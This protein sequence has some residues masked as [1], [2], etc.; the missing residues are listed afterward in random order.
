MKVLQSDRDYSACSLNPNPTVSFA[1]GGSATSFPGYFY[2]PS[3]VPNPAQ[4][5]A[6]PNDDF[7]KKFTIDSAAGNTFRPFNEDTDLYNFGP[8]N[9][10]Q[11]PDT[12]YT[13]GAMGHYELAEAADV[14]AQLMFSD[15]ES[16]AQIAPGGNFFDTNTINCDNPLLSAQQLGTI[17]C[18]AAAIANGDSVTMYLARRNTEGGGRQQRFENASFRAVIG[19]RGAISENWD[20][21]TS[22]QYSAGIADQSANNYFHKTRLT[23]AMNVVTDPGTGDPVCASVLDGSDT[24]CVPYNP[25]QIGGVTPE[26]LAYLQV[27][28]LQ[29]GKIEQEVYSAAVTGD[30]GGYGIQSPLASESIKVAFGA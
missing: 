23:R 6:N 24:T 29:Q 19:L 14:Y 7:L 27:P 18:D 2:F 4:D 13:L 5:P 3:T 20:Y 21:D 9:H 28:G 10:Y 26:A 11:R 15:Y 30:L 8:T 22:V 1:C 12:R 16:V 25:F 17:G